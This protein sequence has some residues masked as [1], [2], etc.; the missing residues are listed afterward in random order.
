MIMQTHKELMGKVTGSSDPAFIIEAVSISTQNLKALHNAGFYRLYRY[1]TLS[2]NTRE[3]QK[4]GAV[5][6][7]TIRLFHLPI[8]SV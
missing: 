7:L 2:D 6:R 8:L 4:A 3:Q 1:Y 5:S